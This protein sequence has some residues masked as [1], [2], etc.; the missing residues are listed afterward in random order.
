MSSRL[1]GVCIAAVLVLAACQSN[2]SSVVRRAGEPDIV[3]VGDQDREMNLAMLHAR[4]TLKEFS[5]RLEHPPSTQTTIA[6]KA[7]FQE[8]EAVEH[9][10]L[11]SISTSYGGFVG[12]IANNP[13]DLV[14]VHLGD[15]VI[16]PLDRVSDWMAI[17]HGLLIGGYTIRVLRDRTPPEQRDAFDKDLG[18][19]IE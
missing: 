16:I 1:R 19:R 7:R 17:D 14:E 13:A 3:L 18:A 6:L 9:I 8:G 5:D 10:W 11:R 15:R 4:E 2:E 12:S